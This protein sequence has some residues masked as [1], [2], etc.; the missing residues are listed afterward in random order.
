MKVLVSRSLRTSFAWAMLVSLTLIASAVDSAAQAMAGRRPPGLALTSRRGPAGGASRLHHAPPASPS[1]PTWSLLL[2]SVSDPDLIP[3]IYAHSAVYDPSS[4]TMVVFGGFDLSNA[5]TNYV[6]VES[7]ANG[8]GGAE[9]GIWS[10]LNLSYPAPPPRAFHSAVY[11]QTNNRMIVFGGCAD[12]YCFDPLN[13]TWVLTNA[14]G[15]GGTSTWIQLTPTGG[16]P[17]ARAFPNTVYDAT[18]NRMIVYGGVG[19]SSDLSDVW[20]LTNANGLGGTP[21]WTQLSPAGGPPNTGDGSAAVYDSATNTLIAFGGDS[22]NNSVWKLSNANGSGG[23]PTWTNLIANGAA[24]SPPGRYYH[25]AVYDSTTNR[26]TIYGGFGN[27][28]P[29][30]PDLDV[31]SYGDVWVLANAN[32]SGGTPV[33]TQL[34]PK[35]NGDGTMQP[36]P[37]GYFSAVRDPGT[38]SL[39]IFGGISVEAGYLSPWVLSHA[40][41]L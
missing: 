20:V 3:E 14:N 7:N 22:F 12:Q 41:G 39:I 21:T 40:N 4:N 15:S 10:E 16:L 26:M 8:S 6:L 37:R 9:A 27:F 19:V 35:F 34:H 31:G 25:Q 36:G 17:T 2:P 28:G 13:D 33:W 23:T 11:D 24:G 38:N 30:N 5:L 18:N 32:G 1:T 29:T